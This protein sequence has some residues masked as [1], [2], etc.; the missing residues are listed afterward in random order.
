MS[1]TW[2][3]DWTRTDGWCHL[4]VGPYDVLR[5]P[6]GVTCSLLLVPAFWLSPAKIRAAMLISGSLLLAI[7]TVGYAYT[8]LLLA[9]TAWGY[10]LTRSLA[11]QEHGPSVGLKVPTPA[12]AVLLALPYALLLAH[13]QPWPLAPVEHPVYFYLQ[14]AGLGFLTLK[15]WHVLIDTLA[16]RF[17]IPPPIAYL[18]YLL[19]PPTLRMGPLYRYPEFAAQ[20]A[21]AATLS[22]PPPAFLRT[23]LFRT[24]LGIARLGAMLALLGACPPATFFSDPFAAGIAH[25]WAA[26]AA[27][28]AAI[29]LWIAGYTDFAVATGRLLGFTVPENFRRP[30]LAT[31]VREF[32]RRWHIPLGHWLRDYIYIPLGGNRRHVE[33]N[34]LATFGAI[35]LWHGLY[36]SYLCWGI[37]QGAALAVQ[38]WWALRSRTAARDP[39]S[40]AM[41]CPAGGS[42]GSSPQGAPDP[43]LAAGAPP[44]AEHISVARSLAWFA[45]IVF[46]LVTIVWFMDEQHAGARFFPAL[47][48][49]RTYP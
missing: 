42:G 3:A 45:T 34:Y 6:L 18:N 33:I 32:W 36:A 40:T 12:A 24:L 17:P 16:G 41:A 7:A 43:P 14:W 28:P 8:A 35:A 37:A 31:S 5:G 21:Y 46:E 30:W 10:A 49:I 38:R 29:Y 47:L 11:R 22:T 25:R 26:L 13:P 4:I 20:M 23:A 19:F 27:L 15:Q 1:P 48:G 9:L 2:I 44:P 39:A